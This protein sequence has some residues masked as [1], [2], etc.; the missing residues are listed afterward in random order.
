[1][2]QKNISDLYIIYDIFTTILGDEMIGK[3]IIGTTVDEE[4][5]F[6]KNGILFFIQDNY[7]SLM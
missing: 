6:T 1:M 3:R 5:S 7:I 2:N 4:L